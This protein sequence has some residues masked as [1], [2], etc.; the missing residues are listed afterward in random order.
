MFFGH[1]MKRSMIFGFGSKVLLPYYL[2]LVMTEWMHAKSQNIW[3][4]QC[5]LASVMKLIRSLAT[6]KKYNNQTTIIQSS[7]GQNIYV[8][9]HAKYFFSVVQAI[10]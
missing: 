2:L 5:H 7:K 3:H 6:D 1:T 8:L 10:K 4:L 9:A